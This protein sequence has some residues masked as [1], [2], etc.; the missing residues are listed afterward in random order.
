MNTIRENNK[1]NIVLRCIETRTILYLAVDNLENMDLYSDRRNLP[2]DSGFDV[3]CI[4]DQTIPANSIS[5]TIHFGI[6]GEMR[7]NIN[8]E[9]NLPIAYNTAY[10]L[11]P[12]SSISKTPLRMSNSIGI[13]D[14]TYRGEI[15]AKVDN[16]LMTTPFDIK[17]GDCFFQLVQGNL[18]PFK[19]EFVNS[20]FFAPT[21]RGTDGFGS[22]DRWPSGPPNRE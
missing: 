16:L 7:H 22:T 10:I 2:G 20:S 1:D 3:V 21:I 4:E 18:N 9:F 19:V 12:R 11:V 13:I 17:R 5:N 15:M 8:N 14:S 6:R